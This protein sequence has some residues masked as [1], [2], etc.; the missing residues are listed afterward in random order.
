MSLDSDHPVR[1][2][3]LVELTLNLINLLFKPSRRFCRLVLG[4]ISEQL[5]GDQF[6]STCKSDV[7]S[8]H[9]V[10]GNVKDAQVETT[11]LS[12][13]KNKYHTFHIFL[14]FYLLMDFR[15]T[16]VRLLIL[17]GFLQIDHCVVDP[18]LTEGCK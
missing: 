12:P 3:C 13:I 14:S 18:V 5:G 11:R 7:V 1:E 8:E 15:D 6:E 4:L 17:Q 16:V 2:L 10:A 9:H